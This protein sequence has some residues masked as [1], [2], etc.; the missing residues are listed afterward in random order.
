MCGA[1][2]T[3]PQPSRGPRCRAVVCGRRWKPFVCQ[4]LSVARVAEAL[5][6][7]WNTANN[8]VLAE[9]QRVLIA[10]P[11]RFDGVRVIGV[12]EH[13]GVTPAAATSTSPSSST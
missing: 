4:H 1:K 6:V 2:T 10:D 13:V 7:S 9:G 11:A 12:D 8:A 3:V 5:A